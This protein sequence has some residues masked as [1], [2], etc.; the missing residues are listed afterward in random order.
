MYIYYNIE[1]A[2]INLKLAIMARVVRIDIKF[3]PYSNNNKIR[4]KERVIVP[5]GAT[6]V[7]SILTTNKGYFQ[8]ERIN[9]EIYFQNY[10]PFRWLNQIKSIKASYKMRSSIELARAIANKEGEYKYGLKATDKRTESLIY[11]ED[12]YLI[13]LNN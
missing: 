9:F 5:L 8:Y 10:S 3:D 7:W 11:E 12:P 13:V 6:I 4:V 2:H 1:H